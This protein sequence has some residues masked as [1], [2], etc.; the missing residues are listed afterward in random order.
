MLR[1][2]TLTTGEIDMAEEAVSDI[3]AQLGHCQLGKNTVG[4]VV[5][6]HDFVTGGVYQ[7]VAS[8]M[9]FP[10]VGFTSYLQTSE[11]G[12]GP[13]FLDIT[14]LTGDDVCFSTAS[15]DPADESERAVAHAYGRASAALDAA[16][17]V[18]FTFISQQMPMENSDYVRLLGDASGGVPSFGGVSINSGAKG[19]PTYVLLGDRLITEGAIML[20]VGGNVRADFGY[21]NFPISNISPVNA[22]VT[23]ADGE[24][25][26]EINGTPMLEYL[27][28]GNYLADGD[29]QLALAMLPILFQPKGAS[30]PIGRNVRGV[31]EQGHIQFFGGVPEGSALRIGRNMIEDIVPI[32]RGLASDMR[33]R[34]PDAKAFLVFSC[35]A[36][37]VAL[38][39]APMSEMADITEALPKDTPLAACYVYG[40]VC[41]TSDGDNRFHNGSIIACALT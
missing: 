15:L 41:P 2:Y 3:L 4:I 9:P 16:P 7:A 27:K 30:R 23:R 20:L 24:W 25:V 21:A 32:A 17:A 28:K 33:D 13:Y 1:S 8:A 38:T 29:L 22:I 40:E 6:H 5:C 12:S 10:L 19:D 34:N 14:V 39:G 11:K 26:R 18:V 35:V 36:R 31:N 37:Y